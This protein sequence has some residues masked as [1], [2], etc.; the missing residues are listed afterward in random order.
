MKR[1]E[2][3]EMKLAGR[4]G[5]RYYNEL[6]NGEYHIIYAHIT[7]ILIVDIYQSIRLQLSSYI[8]SEV[9]R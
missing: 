2:Y 3:L 7:K 4:I 6:E 1:R 8:R 5:N 9:L